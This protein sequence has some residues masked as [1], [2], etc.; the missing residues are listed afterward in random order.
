MQQLS[1][2]EALIIDMD[3]VLWHGDRPQA[4][5]EGFFAI[6][7]QLGLPFLLATNNASM[8]AE[9]YVTKLATMNVTVAAD[10]ILNSVSN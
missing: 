7:R 6:L 1:D 5:I 3:G 2:I 4:G 9:Q 10:E 8:T